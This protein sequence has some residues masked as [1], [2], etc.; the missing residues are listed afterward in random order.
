MHQADSCAH[1]H[2]KTPFDQLILP[3]KIRVIKSLWSL[4]L[5]GAHS[6]AHYAKPGSFMAWQKRGSVCALTGSRDGIGL[7]NG[8]HSLARVAARAANE[9]V[10]GVN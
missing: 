6:R 3:Y 9:F 1:A 2:E 8:P 4:F 10:P 7:P 5:R